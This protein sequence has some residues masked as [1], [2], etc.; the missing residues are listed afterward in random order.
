M[1]KNKSSKTVPLVGLVISA[2][3][4]LG[5]GFGPGGWLGDEEVSRIEG[6]RAK[7]GPLNITV[8]ERGSLRSANSV[9]LKSEVEG[10]STI[11]WLIEEGKH[12]EPGDLL[13]ELDATQTEEK[14]VT[15]E[16]SVQN[17][18]ATLEKAEQQL[19]IQE[20]QNT[21]DIAAAERN[22]EF[23]HVDLAKYI[24][25]EFPQQVKDRE[26]AI[27]LA[28]EQLKRDRDQFE[29]SERLAAKGFV[30]RTEL[31][32]DQLTVKRSEIELDKAQ[33]DLELFTKYEH[34]R[35]LR[36]LDANVE[37]AQRELERVRLQA[38]ARL[39]DYTAEVATSRARL[40]LEQEKLAKY[41]QQIDKAKIFAPVEGMV[42]YAQ[43]RGGRWGNDEPIQEG[44]SVR[45]RQDII[46]IPTTAGMI[47]EASLHESVLEKVQVG[48][49]ALLSFD[50]LPDRKF[51]GRVKFKAHLPDKQSWWSSPD[52]RLYRTEV[53]VLDATAEMRPGMSC[54]IE[55]QVDRLADC[56][57]V[58]VQA[59]FLNR[60]ETVC[61]V[62]DGGD[63]RMRAIET[64]RDN[65]K[66]VEVLSGLEAGE[67]VLLSQPP[68]FS[69]E[70]ALEKTVEEPGE[71]GPPGMPS[72]DAPPGGMP[73]GGMA[74]AGM[75]PAGMQ[76][77]VG[78]GDRGERPSREGGERERGRGRGPSR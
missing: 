8:V 35:S 68:G 9:D 18:R 24:E 5:Y 27:A 38:K 26:Q 72:G 66:L 73:P 21:S 1:K 25:G 2:V 23:A 40:E 42:V 67:V 32:A 28:E 74:P 75:A 16:I 34:P 39:T 29:W 4:A 77:G 58:P 49:E 13:C 60:G 31:E 47:A 22:L 70:P 6:A 64:G 46:T 10:S 65:H 78:G 17:G 56:L 50:A 48:Q 14:R 43:E 55:I 54:S 69:L 51:R 30:T 52:L 33:R 11:L 12:V 7:R 3:A 63:V 62:S 61:F 53:E 41:V 76:P 36:E 37:E 59:V 71:E 19:A 57:Q 45:E 15:Q 20:S 44:T